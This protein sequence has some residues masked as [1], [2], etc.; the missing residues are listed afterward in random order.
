MSD[1]PAPPREGVFETPRDGVTRRAL[2]KAVASSVGALAALPSLT[3]AA[4]SEAL[5]V[6]QQAAAVGGGSLPRF[7]RP[8]ERRTVE[9][10][11]ELVIPADARSPGAKAAGVPEFIDYLLTGA[12]AGTQWIWRDG[13]DALDRAST[14]RFGRRFADSAESEQLAMLNEMSL[15]ER[16][17]GSP[18]EHLF[19][20]IKTRTI[21]GYYTSEIGI[22]RELEYK[23]NQFLEE[24]VGCTHPEHQ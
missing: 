24:F 5:A 3:E 21:Q 2:L 15:G 13:L 1:H 18:L 10:L 12:D 22:H 6:R 19:V 16:N 4:W 14:G 7:L 17:P 23:G 8:D 9:V 11:S 20:E